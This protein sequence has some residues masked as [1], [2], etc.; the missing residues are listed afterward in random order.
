M[1]DY[2]AH[3]VPVPCWGVW[4]AIIVMLWNSATIVVEWFA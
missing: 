2:L 1:R 3:D 4:L